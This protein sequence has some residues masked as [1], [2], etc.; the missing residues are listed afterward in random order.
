MMAAEKTT[1][2]K[3]F[4]EKL[5]RQINSIL[6]VVNAGMKRITLNEKD[7]EN[8]IYGPGRPGGQ[9]LFGGIGAAET[10]VISGTSHATPGWVE[11]LSGK[12]AGFRV[13]ARS[14]TEGAIVTLRTVNVTGEDNPGD[15]ELDFYDNDTRS[16][17]FLAA[18]GNAAGTRYG[19]WISYADRDGNKLPF[20][21]F[22]QDAAGSAYSTFAWCALYV[23]A[24]QAVGTAGPIGIGGGF[25]PESQPSAHLHLAAGTTTRAPFKLTSGALRT[26]PA[27]G[28]MEFL[29]DAL[30]FTITTGATRKTI[31]FTS[32]LHSA[33]SLAT[34]A[35]VLLGLG[36]TGGQVLSL[37]TQAANKVLAG[38]E[39]GPNAAPTFRALAGADLPATTQ[40]DPG[41]CPA[42]GVPSGKFL[43]DDLTW[44]TPS[45]AS[46][47]AGVSS[48]NSLEGALTLVEGANITIT[49]DEETGEIEIAATGGA[50][51][52]VSTLNGLDG[53]LD[54]VAGDNV[55]VTEDEETGQIEIAAAGGLAY[56]QSIPGLI[57]W[58]D[59][60]NIPHVT[61]GQAVLYV[62]NEALNPAGS[63][64]IDADAPIL[65][66]SIINGHSVM[67][68]DG[69][70]DSL[71]T[72]DQSYWS[73]F[74][75]VGF[76]VFAV[77][78]SDVDTG[79][80]GIISKMAASNYEWSL[81]FATPDVFRAQLLLLPLAGG[82]YASVSSG[83]IYKNTF[84]IIVARFIYNVSA[85]IWVNGGAGIESTSFSGSMGDGSA[86]VQLGERGDGQ[87]LDGDLACGGIFN[88]ALSDAELDTL[89]SYLGTKYNLAVTAV[90]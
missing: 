69:T 11:V 25:K 52:G 75:T 32:D 3:S 16:F 51:A 18:L 76:T 1:S 10:L 5:D 56:P 48:L 82:S 40:T 87:F 27:A 70:D 88:R 26:S 7:L 84:N 73:P 39:S 28:E 80:H 62:R 12:T 42:T 20:A 77:V 83:Q 71:L 4:N 47:S 55:T 23:S 53:D 72:P 19:G 14:K 21:I 85:K 74:N 57:A 36:G 67:R 22:T 37:D 17:R 60:D 58:W 38:P 79:A 66:T 29:T 90:S 64:K 41:A 30:Y 81:R 24:G 6:A 68:F 59:A 35:D 34:S 61:D 78:S 50:A 89:F 9:V 31:A 33:V 63:M 45:G 8:Y 86:P 65:K 2:F 49:E 13:T 46:A 44:D 43:K 54:I 15:A